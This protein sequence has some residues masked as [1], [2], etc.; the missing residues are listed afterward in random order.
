MRV[1]LL[2]DALQRLVDRS[3]GRD[4]AF[5]R[6]DDARQRLP[7]VAALADRDVGGLLDPEEDLRNVTDHGVQLN[8]EHGE[9]ERIT[10]WQS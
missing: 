2:E 10:E 1:C 7:D 9:Y 3:R 4:I 8:P 6:L 5:A